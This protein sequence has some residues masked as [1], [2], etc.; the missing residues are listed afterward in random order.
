ME[1]DFD[2]YLKTP[3]SIGIFVFEEDV[4]KQADFCTG[5][6]GLSGVNTD[7]L[8]AWLLRYGAH[9]DALCV[10]IAE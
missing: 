3:D 10:E 9:S 6:A 5:A 7:T 8:K 1:E 4:A 2:V